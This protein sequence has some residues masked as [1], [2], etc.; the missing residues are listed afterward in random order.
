MSPSLH[1]DFLVEFPYCWVSVW[2]C[3]AKFSLSLS[4]SLV[5][6][7]VIVRFVLRCVRR[8]FW[9]LKSVGH[10]GA[11]FGDADLLNDFPDLWV[12]IWAT[13]GLIWGSLIV[14]AAI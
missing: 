14:T 1:G 6:S 5:V 12:S 13:H 9:K 7:C 3:F 4:L 11:V 10:L 2:A 8:H